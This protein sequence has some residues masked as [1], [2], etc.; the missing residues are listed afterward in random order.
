MLP[1]NKSGLRHQINRHLDYV[2]DVTDGLHDIFGGLDVSLNVTDAFIECP[3]GV[4]ELSLEGLRV[5]DPVV[6]LI[7]KQSIDL[8]P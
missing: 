5:A 8:N 3:V 7:T 2:V 4:I 6:I 1:V